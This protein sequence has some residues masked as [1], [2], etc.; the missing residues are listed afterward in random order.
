ML[1]G[2]DRA[3]HRRMAGMTTKH[4][5]VSLHDVI[6]SDLE[7]FLTLIEELWGDGVVLENISYKPVA[8]TADGGIQL[9]VTATEYD[10]R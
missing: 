7:G 3:D 6:D 4:L 10:W 9:E 5:T 1:S 8:V 2:L